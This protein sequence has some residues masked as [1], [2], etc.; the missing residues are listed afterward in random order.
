[1][2]NDDFDMAS[3]LNRLK[4]LEA[5]NIR[6]KSKIISYSDNSP[7]SQNP[8]EGFFNIALDLMCIADTQGN[9]VKVNKSWEEVLGYSI[10]YLENH[11]FLEFVHP[12]DMPA[13]LDALSKLSQQKQVLNFVNRYKHRDGSWRY[14]E[15]RSQP[16]GKLIYAAARDITQRIQS[17]IALKGSEERFSLV[18]DATEL[19]V[20]DWNLITNEVYYSPQWKKQVG[21]DDHELINEFK[22]WEDLLHPD[23]FD[24]MHREVAQF[25]ANP[26]EHFRAEFRLRHKE[27]H[28]VWIY[29]KASA[30]KNKDG[31]VVRFIGSH[32]DITESKK[33]AEY[34][35]QAKETYQGILDSLSEAVYIQDEKG[36]FVE[37]NQTVEMFYGYPRD[38]FIGKTPEFLSAPNRNDLPEVAR[39][40]DAAFNGTPGKF[41]FWGI[42][43]D[44]IIFPKEVSVSPGTY[45]GQRV[46][47]AVARNISER[48]EAELQIKDKTEQIE[49]QNEEYRQLN[50]EL[51][52]AK[53][54][55]ERSEKKFRS[56]VESAFDG[57]YLLSG[58]HFDYVNPR[59]AE[60]TGFEV[61]ELTHRDFDFTSLFTE[62]TKRIVEDRYQLRLKG[63]TSPSRYEFQIVT[64]G[65]EIKDLE[66]S[67]V[68]IGSSEELKI[69]G[70]VKDITQRR[71]MEK[72][73]AYQSKLQRLL[74]GLGKKFINI[75]PRDIDNEINAALAEMGTFSDV[76]RTYIFTYDFEKNTMSNTYEWCAKGISKEI[77]NLQN[78]PN[79]LVSKWVDTHIK[80][81]ILYFPNISEL[82]KDDGVRAILEAQSVK[83]II[84]IPM[85]HNEVCLGFVGFDSV[86]Q[87]KSWAEAEISLLKLFADLLVNVQVKTKYE[88]SLRKAK[89][90]AEVK[91]MEVRNIIDY[92]PVGIILIS[93]T[94]DVI[95]VNES[96]VKMLGS[97]SAEATKELNVYQIEALDNIGFN[98]EFSSCIENNAMVHNES[99]YK[100]IWGKEIYVKYYL[101]P[102]IV[103]NQVESVVANIED[104]TQIKEAQQKLLILKEKA[105]ES[106]RLKTAF[107]SNMSHEIRTPMN[108]ICGFSNLLLNKSISDDQK[109]N[110]VEIININS[111][112]LLSIINDIIDVSKI[113]AG[114]VSVSS[115]KFSINNLL[116]ETR[117]IFLPNIKAK[118][119]SLLCTMGLPAS[120]SYIVS[121]ELK[122]KQVLNNLI[123]NAIKFTEAGQIDLGYRVI[124]KNIEFFVKDTGIG[125]QQEHFEEVFERFRQIEN[126]T[127]DSRKGTGL[128]LP[129]SKAFVELLGG[130]I[131]LTSDLGKGS[132][133]YF[134][135]P[136]VMAN[137]SKPQN[138]K[139]PT[140]KISWEGKTIL[141]AEDD[142]PNLMY[143]RELLRETGANILMAKN[144][145]DVIS[146]FNDN[147]VDLILMDIK[148]PMLNGL[149]ATKELRRQGHR[150][151]IIAQTAYA[152]S[153][154]KEK[155][156]ESGCNDYISKPIRQEEL[157]GLIAKWLG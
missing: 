146:L 34:I 23:D 131:W 35:R 54:S 12:E 122:V 84:T 147:N 16:L 38:Y 45:F 43:K 62:Q 125:I 118:G 99:L 155:S 86:K 82:S 14:I 47:I 128:G 119:L 58:K 94:G 57:I 145:A 138:E 18:I 135:I 50:Q 41:E 63:E 91:Q 134:T 124:D 7:G 100:S 2:K 123:Y 151:P 107:L 31:N 83:S 97:P 106:D 137:D 130:Q 21:Y 153:D 40:I 37:V 53:E 149:E 3:Q 39:A 68:P 90:I 6:L 108:A 143:L 9:F 70:I 112:Q 27:G 157:L 93:P 152:F 102:I 141:I 4:E 101:V 48:K 127:N 116:E 60:I 73:I 30:L 11:T 103:N 154:D 1:M 136:Y 32:S 98:R 13:T 25:L 113:E 95:D 114:Q 19:G 49:A 140:E 42:R 29:N 85:L 65:K 104:I 24:R 67:T 77:E 78:I 44:G 81:E 132:T 92:S 79:N 115:N 129:I 66:I 96:A 139:K 17:E 51:Y 33:N 80:G 72:E 46:V 88:L 26:K 144:G 109:E 55:I 28:Y 5:E 15:W 61:E 150:V 148:M 76:D 89:T 74:L 71:S 120:E 20:W 10:E 110:F 36:V 59:F 8:Y 105:E 52:T 22:T 133:F 121:D 126:T 111:Q 75:H 156:L 56:L 64:K 117:T 87:L 142:H 69:M